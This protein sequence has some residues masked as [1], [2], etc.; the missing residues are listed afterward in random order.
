MADERIVNNVISRLKSVPLSDVAFKELVCFMID[1]NCESMQD[2]E[3][4]IY[5]KKGIVVN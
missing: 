1:N 3:R 4:A 5:I 2:L